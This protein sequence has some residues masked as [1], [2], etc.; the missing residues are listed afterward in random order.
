MK[1]TYAFRGYKQLSKKELN[2]IYSFIDRFFIW[3]YRSQ[4]N[5]L[6]MNTD[7]EIIV[8]V[9]NY[10]WTR[11]SISKGGNDVYH[12]DVTSFTDINEFKRLVKLIGSLQS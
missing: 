1:I 5:C 2:K 11:L 3:D 6:F 10:K 9:H 4:D 7:S 12:K 8:S